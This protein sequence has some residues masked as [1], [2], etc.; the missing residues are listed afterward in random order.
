MTTALVFGREFLLHE[1]SPSHP[2]RRERLAYTIDQFEEEGLFHHDCVRVLS[3]VKATKEQ[4]AVVHHPRYIEFLEEASRT[5]GV[6]DYDTLVP[7]G[8][9]DSALLAAVAQS[10]Q[11]SQYGGE[12]LPTRSPSSD[13]QGTMHVPGLVLGS[14]T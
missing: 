2:E 3:P 14:V 9:L 7:E 11:A 13:R 4:V 10:K 6:I 8:L 1:Q 12:N 5:G